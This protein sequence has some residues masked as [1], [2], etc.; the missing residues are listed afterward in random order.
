MIPSELRVALNAGTRYGA[1]GVDELN[2][3]LVVALIVIRVLS[4]FCR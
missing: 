4:V 3:L 1:V 2:S